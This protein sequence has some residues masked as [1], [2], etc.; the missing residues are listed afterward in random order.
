MPAPTR[1]LALGLAIALAAAPAR[2]QPAAEPV[3]V[4][5]AASLKTAL[6]EVA[7][8]FTAATGIPV[9]FSFAA[10]S[11]LARQ[12]EAGAPADLFASADREWMDHLEGRGL[13]GNGTR[14]DLLGNRLVVVAPAGAPLRDLA[15]DAASIRAAVGSGRIATGEVT[16]VPVGRYAKAALE[17]LNL[18]DE[19]RPRLAQAENV[20]AALAFVARGEAPLGIVYETDARAEPRVRVVATFPADS[21][22]PIVYPFALTAGARQAEGARRLLAHLAGPQARAVFEAQGFTVLAPTRPATE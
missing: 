3:T 12:I 1:R 11:A 8:P 18:W 10:S 7:K 15:L 16:S 13:V 17:R 5:A 19:V 14:R 2:A 22:P 9:R 6:E 21:H 20:R 4:F